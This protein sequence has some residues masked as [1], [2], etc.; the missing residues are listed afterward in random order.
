LAEY[1]VVL[2]DFLTGALRGRYRVDALAYSRTLDDAG[3]MSATLS[4]ADRRVLYKDPIGATT[5][6]K[7]AVYVERNESQIMWG[8]IPWTRRRQSAAPGKLDIQGTEFLSY[9]RRRFIV[10]TLVFA[11]Q[12]QL[13]IARDLVAYAQGQ[14]MNAVTGHPITIAKPGGSLGITLGSE[15]SGV[16]RDRTYLGSERKSIET[17]LKELASVDNGFD[18]SIDPVY[19]SGLGS[20]ITRPLALSYPRRGK[21]AQ[22]STLRWEFGSQMTDYD[23]PEDA[24]A[25]ATTSYAVGAGEG[26][27][28][29]QSSA[30]AQY[31]ID[32]GYPLL[33]TSRPYKDV[34]VQATLDSHAV[35]DSKADGVPAVILPKIVV[36]GDMDP[37]VGEYV[38]GDEVAI[39]IDD[40][41]FPSWAPAGNQ[42]IN[43]YYRIQ[44]Y[45]V[46]V[47]SVG[48]EVVTVTLGPVLPS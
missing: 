34:T 33:E 26:A 36:N 43:S 27:T 3:V 8:G 9:L 20:S 45:E 7:T 35:A 15:T 39:V 22:Q 47:D 1:S 37:Q 30:S 40:E 42:S 13:A 16:L 12:D 25:I 10:D 28:M 41:N 29:L 38:C 5:L 14:A 44:A 24:T 6:A 4:Y 11:A 17:A 32:A 2:T 18:F 19:S 21:P 23:W 46:R 48:R 31:L